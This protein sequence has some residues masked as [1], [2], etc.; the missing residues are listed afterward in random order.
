M[1]AIITRSVAKSLVKN[2]KQMQKLSD[3][4]GRAKWLNETNETHGNDRYKWSCWPPRR[5]ES[6]HILL[7]ERD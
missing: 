7:E 6:N 1:D 3:R 5:R 2:N 4:S